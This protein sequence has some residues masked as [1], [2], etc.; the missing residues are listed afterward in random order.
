LALIIF[1]AVI[2]AEYTAPSIY[3]GNSEAASELEINN[4]SS[5]KDLLKIGFPLF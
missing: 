5:K 4:L 3:P 1:L 2:F